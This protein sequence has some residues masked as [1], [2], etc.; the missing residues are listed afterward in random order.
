M[1]R[2][3]TI[4]AKVVLM[5]NE[6]NV[7]MRFAVISDA[8]ISYTTFSAN[9]ILDRLIKYASAIGDL[10][11]I[12][13]GKL[14]AVMMCGDYSSIGCKEQAITFAQSTKVIFENIFGKE[15][16]PKLLIGMGNHDTC[17]RQK[18]Y[19][20]MRADGWYDIFENY[21]L[22]SD[23][24]EKSDR[25]NGNIRMDV[26]KD[27]VQYSFLYAETEDYN[28]NV[29]KAETLKWLDD[30]LC[31]I[32]TKNPN[33]YVF[34]GTHGPVAET[35]IYGTVKELEPG[36]DWGT[37]KGNIDKIFSKYPQVVVFSG[38]THMSAELETT[39]MQTNYTAINVPPVMS[40]DYYNSGEQEFVN[41]KYASYLD[42]TYPD[43]Q[44]GMGMYIEADINGNMRIRRVN[45][46][47]NRARIAV[48]NV[49]EKAN[50]AV[51]TW[52]GEPD[53]FTYL[54][55]RDCEVTKYEEPSF[56]MPDWILKMPDKDGN[57]LKDYSK[58]RGNVRIPY[59][60]ADA[61][62]IAEKCENG[63]IKV[64]FPAANS[65]RYILYYKIII[66]AENKADKE[67]RALGNWVDIKKGVTEGNSHKDAASFEYELP[68][69]TENDDNYE[70]QIIAVDEYGNKSEPVNAK[71]L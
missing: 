35:K 34:V 56:F 38:H 32:T 4:S 43:N 39:I 59:F 13:G 5:F 7:V 30:M 29:F 57:F 54:K 45:F 67:F 46:S 16:M 2:K 64:K 22:T 31:E 27:G 14:D 52:P 9:D 10:K 21:G 50:P 69:V 60:S 70:I 15:N 3:Q 48:K 61:H 11:D 68:P 17:W 71:I 47:R 28:P 1:S 65:E 66:K 40:R 37:S 26:E 42:S 6:K 55:I 19:C 44:H 24:S 12:S 20:S 53:S 8:H 18:H 36:A 23:F 25:D 62:I 63:S 49:G 58:L 51:G 41:G 33:Q